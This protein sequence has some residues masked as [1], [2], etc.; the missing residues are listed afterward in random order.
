M[1]TTTT[2]SYT[3]I[4]TT[5]QFFIFIIIM[6]S[7]SMNTPVP[8]SPSITPNYLTTYNCI[9]KY[10]CICSETLNSRR[11]NQHVHHYPYL[12]LYFDITLPTLSS[13]P[14]LPLPLLSPLLLSFSSQPSIYLPYASSNTFRPLRTLTTETLSI[15]ATISRFHMRRR[16]NIPVCSEGNLLHKIDRYI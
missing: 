3:S 10:I 16:T 1:K 4:T 12:Y 8:K 6:C 5:F 15:G 7:V 14:P 2:S 13:L 11:I 9:H